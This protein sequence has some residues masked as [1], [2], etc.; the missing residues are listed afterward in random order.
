MALSLLLTS[1]MSCTIS[2]RALHSMYRRNLNF[3]ARLQSSSSYHS[4][5]ILVTGVFNV[6]T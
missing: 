5:K 4:F 2:C 6:F 1:G 3:K